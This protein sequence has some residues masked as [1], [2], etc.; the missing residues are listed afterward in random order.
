MRARMALLVGWAVV[1]LAM[2]GGP[3]HAQVPGAVDGVLGLYPVG[4]QT[5]IAVAIALKED[6]ALAGVTWFNND[7]QAAFQKVVVVAGEKGGPPALGEDAVV[8]DQPG[9]PSSGWGEVSLAVGARSETGTLY[10][11]FVLPAG[12]EREGVGAGGGPGIGYWLDGSG[13]PGYVSQDGVEWAELGG[14]ITLAVWPVMQIGGGMTLATVRKGVA[15]P[16]VEV[17]P[18]PSGESVPAPHFVTELSSAAPNPFNPSTQIHFTLESAGEAT[19]TVY[20][21]RG[22]VVRRLVAASLPEGPH[23]VEWTGTDEHGQPIAS[24]VYVVELVAQGSTQTKRI[25]LVR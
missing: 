10:A 21:L 4:T 25:A 23:T 8:I 12:E 13:L 20:N 9:A 3:L 16:A 24:G 14:G 7:G 5:C 18:E 17:E 22:A 2:I 15:F 11:I 19:V 1:I 6:E